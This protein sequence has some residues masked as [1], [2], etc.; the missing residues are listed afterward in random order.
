MFGVFDQ[1]FWPSWYIICG[2]EGFGNLGPF[3]IKPKARAEE[4]EMSEDKQRKSRL[5][6]YTAKDDLVLGERDHGRGKR[7]ATNDGL[8]KH[9]KG[10]H[11]RSRPAIGAWWRSNSRR[12]CHLCIKCPQLTSWPHLCGRDPWIVLSGS[13]QLTE[14][15]REWQMGCALKYRHGWLTSVGPG[16]L[17]KNYIM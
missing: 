1:N 9:P 15:Q 2:A 13:P 4:E 17:K 16:W 7:H 14:C 3:H 8:L 6:G 12:G 10:K 5:S 11:K